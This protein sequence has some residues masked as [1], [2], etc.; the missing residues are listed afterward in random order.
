MT[1]DDGDWQE[2]PNQAIL[3]AA[4]IAA[5][6]AVLGAALPAADVL[7]GV[8]TSRTYSVAERAIDAQNTRA[9]ADRKVTAAGPT[10]STPPRVKAK[11]VDAVVKERPAV[12][13]PAKAARLPP[14]PPLRGMDGEEEEV[15]SRLRLPG[16]CGI[17]LVPRA[18]KAGTDDAEVRIINAP[19]APPRPKK[20]RAREQDVAELTATHPLPYLNA[21]P[22]RAIP[23]QEA[24]AMYN[25]PPPPRRQ[26]AIAALPSS[27]WKMVLAAPEVEYSEFPPEV[28]FGEFPRENDWLLVEKS[29]VSGLSTNSGRRTVDACEVVHFAFPSYGWLHAG[30]KM[31]AKK[32]AALEQIVR[33]STKRAGEIGKLSPEW[34]KCLVPLVNSSK[35][36]IQGKI[37]FPTTQLRLMQ[38]VLLYVSFY[39]HKSVF[40]E[41]D[42]SS[43][44]QLAP[45]NVDYSDNPLQALFKLLKLKASIK[46][47]FTLEE[48][49]RKR[50]WN[51][52]GDANEDAESTPI[53]GLETRLTSGQTFPEQGADEQ[54]I[55]EAALN[56]II[57]T[58]ETYDLKEA[59]PPHTLVSVLKPY[60]KEALFWMSE[61]EKGHIQRRTQ[62]I[63][64]AWASA[65]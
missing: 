27:E 53:V 2:S 46:A 12:P 1:R 47:D 51:L 19:A 38:E 41:G 16:N 5:V 11:V 18:A 31:S 39:I 25:L 21:R 8:G 22:I 59:E 56:K 65:S 4:E 42:N 44:S 10:P 52:R 33:F 48:L 63:S 58:A 20:K 9:K 6:R 43:L 26:R 17:S 62:E 24:A 49:R 30:V 14:P 34:T 29:Y 55:S 61:L 35:V 57:G 32:A 64:K 50:P 54:A 13:L 60:Q 3:F 7:D 36:K 45:A 23:P 15:T 37:V 40:T 28:E